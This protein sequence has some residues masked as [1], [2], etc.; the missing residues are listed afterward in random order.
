M[1]QPSN[2]RLPNDKNAGESIPIRRSRIIFVMVILITA[3]AIIWPGHAVF[4]SA[5][6]L[7]FGFPLSF[8][9]IIFWVIVGFSAMM[10]LYLSDSHE[11]D[12]SEETN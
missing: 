12:V 8:A 11:D 1:N 10:G 4:S 6:P 3:L 7:I 2:S 5:T 9:W